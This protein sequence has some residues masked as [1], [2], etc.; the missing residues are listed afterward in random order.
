MVCLAQKRSAGKAERFFLA[1]ETEEPIRK[2][3]NQKMGQHEARWK[4][5]TDRV[6]LFRIVSIAEKPTG[7]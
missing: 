3:G 1:A 2:P 6:G 4:A 5:T 7:S